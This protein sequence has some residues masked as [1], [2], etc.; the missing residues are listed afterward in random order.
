MNTF[1]NKIDFKKIKI[2]KILILIVLSIIITQTIELIS[3]SN[4][5]FFKNFC[6]IFTSILLEAI[7]FILI[8]SFISSL[9]QVFVSEEFVTRII[10]KNKFLGLLL[11]SLIGIVFPVCECTIV[12]ITKKLIKKGVPLGVAFTFMLSVPI[13]NPIVLM[14]TYYAFYNKFSIFIIRCVGGI[15]GSILIGYLI[16]LSEGKNSKDICI[17]KSYY[18][19]KISCTCGCES[20]YSIYTYN[21]KIKLILIHTINELFNIIKYLSIGAFLSTLFQLTVSKESISSIG[22]NIV[23]SV[24]AMMILAFVLSVCSE[25]DAFIART[26]LNEFTVGSIASFLI[27]GPMI[28]IKNAIMLFGNFR[29]N[30]IVKLIFYIFTVCYIIGVLVNIIGKLGVI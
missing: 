26:F 24:I 4:I 28:D 22:N 15:L 17:D 11:A 9:I 7:P 5:I 19:D 10:P 23:L 29:R 30:I 6:T 16:S 13:V 3:D 14:S 27:L 8:G 21:S 2:C 18:K 12:P 20:G 1:N 25:A